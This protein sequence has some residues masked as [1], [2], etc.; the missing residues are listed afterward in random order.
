MI[1]SQ[2]NGGMIDIH[3][4]LRYVAMMTVAATPSL[5]LAET[6]RGIPKVAD[7]RAAFSREGVDAPGT[8]LR[9]KRGGRLRSGNL[10]LRLALSRRRVLVSTQAKGSG[11][12]QSGNVDASWC[13]CGTRA[14][15][16]QESP[17]TLLR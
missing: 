3:T 11:I 9:R 7:T 16:L 5:P 14:I 4:C 2:V 10:Q 17:V 6:L 13:R 12:K 15:D 1:A 8:G